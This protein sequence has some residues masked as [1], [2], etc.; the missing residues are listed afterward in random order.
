MRKIDCPIVFICDD[1][2]AM[3]TAVAISSI[4]FNKKIDLEYFVYVLSV[5]VCEKKVSRF[6][7]LDAPDFHVAVIECTL[8]QKQMEVVQRRE[9]VTQ[10]ALLKFDLPWL[11]PDCDKLLYLD[12][13]VIVQKDLETLINQ[14]IDGKYAAVVKDI[15]TF[16]GKE[17]HLKRIKFMP[18]VYFNSGMLLMNTKK[19]REDGI[20]DKLLEYR[21]N[22]KNVFMD[23]DALN[24]VFDGQVRYVSPYY[25]LLNC[26]FEWETMETLEA[27][28]DVTFPS[29]QELTYKNS[30]VLHYG[31]KKKPWQYEM[32]YLSAI[33]SVYYQLSP[34]ASE[35]LTLIGNR[36]KEKNAELEEIKL[37]ASYRIGRGITWLPR[38]IRGG[39]QCIKDNGIEYTCKHLILKVAYIL[40][41][42]EKNGGSD[43]A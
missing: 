37:S 41:I 29:T 36:N 12:S 27:F 18:E 6:S 2:Y 32:G 15:M 24:V 26:F 14:D 4:K 33:Y 10:A 40:H 19:M 38:K 17:T 23:Q 16:R 8:N 20:S 7:E 9:R 5:D 31:D 28:Y 35:P 42:K 43:H 25:N 39:I 13:D 21:L 22:G 3:P 34:Y 30:V 1:K 11:F